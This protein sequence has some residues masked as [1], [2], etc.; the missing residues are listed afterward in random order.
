M[1]EDEP[2]QGCYA[3][4]FHLR[5]Q[6]GLRERHVSSLF[7]KDQLDVLNTEISKA[8]EAINIRLAD[9]REKNQQDEDFSPSAPLVLSVDKIVEN[10]ENGVDQNE[11]KQMCQIHQ[12][13]TCLFP[14]RR[15]G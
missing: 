9:Q 15:I 7:N 4:S 12:Q 3:I 11:Q 2:G 1:R 13:V 8:V 10:I 5:D 6:E 14:L